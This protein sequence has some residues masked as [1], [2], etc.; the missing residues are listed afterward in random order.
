MDN[1]LDTAL[2][3]LIARPETDGERIGIAGAS[4]GANLAIRGGSRYPQ[5]KSVVMLSPALDYRGIT[6]AEAL[7]NYGQRATMIVATEKDTLSA[8]PARTLNSRALGQH[9]LQIYPGSDHGTNIFKAQA[10]LKPMMLAWFK[11]TL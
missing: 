2:F 5:V 3:W 6:S 1:D 10:G 8:D 9:Q 4:I 11:S 7:S